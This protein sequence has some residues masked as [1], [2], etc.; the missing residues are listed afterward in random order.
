MGIYLTPGNENYRESI[1]FEAYV[2]KTMMLD[3]LNKY[4]EEGNKYV[5]V[6]RP[7]R[8]GKTIAQN[9]INAYY[10]KGCDSAD[11]FSR[12]KISDVEGY[13]ENLN[14]FNVIKIDMNG[15]YQSAEEK[16]KVLKNLTRKIKREMKR[17]FRDLDFDM[18]DTLV[19]M[20]LEVYG[21]TG[22]TFMILIDEYDVLVRE[23]VSQDLFDE[24]LS[25]LGQP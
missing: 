2:D 15:E 11:I 16:D 21:E 25:F 7:R 24:Y 5:C 1:K 8:F 22:E 17:A 10:S 9:M 20:M 13:K 23:Q 12:M 19:D 14:R 18:E 3:V 4:I 6:S